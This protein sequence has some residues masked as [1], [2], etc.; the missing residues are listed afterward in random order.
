[1]STSEMTSST[2]SR[3]L[4]SS[5]KPPRTACS[6][7]I[8]WGKRFFSATTSA[9]GSSKDASDIGNNYGI[10]LRPGIKNGHYKQPGKGVDSAR[11]RHACHTLRPLKTSECRAITLQPPPA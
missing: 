8:E 1:K 5:I 2:A 7:S 9:D 4:L 3:R 6:A 11:F 10:I